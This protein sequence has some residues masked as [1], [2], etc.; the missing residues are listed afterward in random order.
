MRAGEEAEVRRPFRGRR[1]VQG[2][3]VEVHGDGGDRCHPGPWPPH[4]PRRCPRAQP[5]APA[6]QGLALLVA[7]HLA[8][9]LRGR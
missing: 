7:G 2:E 8:V 9:W 1:A 6:P 4:F 5:G 3:E